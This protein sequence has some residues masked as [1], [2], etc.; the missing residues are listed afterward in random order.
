MSPLDFSSYR[1]IVVLTGAGV[2]VA[3]GLPPYRG[4]GGLWGDL[5]PQAVATKKSLLETPEKV[6]ELCKKQRTQVLQS[7][8]NPAHQAL[9]ALE[10]SLLPSQSFL[11]IT[12]NVDGLHV[13]A[14]SKKVVALHGEIC[15]T[16]CSQD[17][18]SLQPFEDT[19]LYDEVPHCSV[20]SSPL[21]PDIVLFD[22]FIPVDAEW[23]TKRAL[24]DCDFFLAIGTSG[25][26]SPASNFVRSADY[27]GAR[28]IYIN[29]AAMDPP[30]PYFHESY[31]GK[32][33]ELLPQLFSF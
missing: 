29:L 18:C 12:Q 24:R 26:I 20:C 32:A 19:Q 13:R 6:W 30:N 28:T 21:R 25:T 15:R 3:S 5:D 11:L 1:K 4:A 27:A 14:G 2:S 10:A 17:A 33:E 8:P 31:L 16:R 22:E 7:E 23:A 9:A